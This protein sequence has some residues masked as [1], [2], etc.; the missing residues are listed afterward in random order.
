MVS[1]EII[2][3]IL[4]LDVIILQANFARTDLADEAASRIKLKTD[5][6][7]TEA[8]HFGSCA[9]SRVEINSDTAALALGKPKGNYYTVKMEEYTKRRSNAFRDCVTAISEVLRSFQAITGAK[10]FLIACLGNK[11]VTPDA[12]GP[13]TADGIIVTR[14]LK[15]SLPEQFAALSTVSV[16]RTGVLGTTGIES[17]DELAAVCG[18]IK[19]DCVLAVDA[20]ATAELGRLCKN[21]QICDTGISP[22]SGVGNNRGAVNIEALGVPVIAIGVP[23]VIDAAAFT[24]AAEAAGLFVTPRNIDELVRSSAKLIAYGINLAL[25]EGLTVEDV[26]LLVE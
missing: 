24:D 8:L 25:H 10:S 26:D 16:V 12:L 9:V 7:F 5:G 18:H 6:V 23:T 22:G 15:A 11:S 14:H 2:H 13:Y 19:P 1:S 17:V 21:V 4:I 20:L 3:Y